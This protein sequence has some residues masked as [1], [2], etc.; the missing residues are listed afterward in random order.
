LVQKIVTINE[1]R[2]CRLLTLAALLLLF[3]HRLLQ[4]TACS[5][6]AG[7][8]G[9]LSNQGMEPCAIK[10]QRIVVVGAGSA[11][12]GVTAMIA[13]GMIKHG[14]T[15]EQAASHF[16]VVDA[17]GLVTHHRDQLLPHV[18]SFA[19]WDKSSSD[20]ESLLDVVRRVKPTGACT[21][22]PACISCLCLVRCVLI[23]QGEAVCRNQA[24]WLEHAALRSLHAIMQREHALLQGGS[25]HR[26]VMC[27][28]DWMQVVELLDNHS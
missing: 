14:F 21:S 3:K 5:A 7:V 25:L 19:R 18:Q 23:A 20:G 12:M 8:Y 27:R 2:P 22:L 4:G 10:N 28:W 6:L 24:R 15:A 1:C 9:A 13:K 26:G 17:N 16:W 11:G